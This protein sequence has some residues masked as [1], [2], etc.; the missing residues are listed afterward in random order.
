M[1]SRSRLLEAQSDY[2]AFYLRTLQQWETQFQRAVSSADRAT[3]EEDLQQVRQAQRW[4][5]DHSEAYTFAAQLCSTFGMIDSVLLESYQ[6]PEAQVNWYRAALEAARLLKNTEAELHHLR[7]LALSYGRMGEYS[8]G[9]QHLQDA[10]VRH[11]SHADGNPIVRAQLLN[12]I[13]DMLNAMGE[14]H[15]SEAHY[16]ESLSLS[17][18]GSEEHARTLW[19]L[20]GVY[21]TLSRLD[22]AIANAE[23][24]WQHHQRTGNTLLLAQIAA[25]MGEIRYTQ[26]NYDA[27]RDHQWESIRLAEQIA[28]LRG[29]TVAYRNLAYIA[30]DQGALQESEQHFE[31]SLTYVQQLGDLREHAILLGG[32]GQFQWQRGAYIQAAAS[33]RQSFAYCEQTGDQIGMAYMLIN[34]GKVYQHTGDFTQAFREL[35]QAQTILERLGEPWGQAKVMMSLGE[36]AQKQGDHARAT[37][38]FQKMLISVETIGDV[39]GQALAWIG[40]GKAAHG[41]DQAEEALTAYQRALELARAISV[42]PMVLEALLG[43]AEVW[44]TQ[45]KIHASIELLGFLIHH[46]Q[47]DDETRLACTALL[48]RMR[49][50]HRDEPIDDLLAQGAQRDIAHFVNQK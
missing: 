3:F 33:F 19:G 27:A 30:N 6:T 47:S 50:E 42:L 29:L 34:L 4:C 45:G 16:L 44:Y 18:A 11:S 39:R 15:Q 22:E 13:G 41:R 2:A 12:S 40:L 48:S 38:H 36:L 17:T 8:E 1:V 46:P 14:P 21:N 35:E 7:H 37:Q 9:L 10:L 31:R 20:S 25:R 43:V 26:G 49:L 23:Q 32:L 24:S 5:A 28:Y